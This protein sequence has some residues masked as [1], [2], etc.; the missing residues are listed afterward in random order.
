M[1]PTIL[2]E[3]WYSGGSVFDNSAGGITEWQSIG[4]KTEADDGSGRPRPPAS[5]QQEAGG[6]PD[7]VAHVVGGRPP[8][9]PRDQ[10][11]QPDRSRSIRQSPSGR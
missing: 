11:G 10:V 1:Q 7:V 3:Y 4:P 6:E 8:A 9:H 2:W 5:A